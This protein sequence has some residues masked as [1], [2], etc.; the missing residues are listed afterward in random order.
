MKFAH[1]ADSHL[2]F[3]QYGLYQREEDFFD[4]FRRNIDKIINKKVDFVIHSGDLF[5]MPKP[6][7]K[8]LL[9][10]Q[11][12]LLKLR[13]ADIDVFAIAGN[14]DT[15]MRKDALPPQILSKNLGLKLISPKNPYY[16]YENVFIGG[17][18]YQSKPYKSNLIDAFKL[19]SQEAEKYEKRILVS[20]QGIDK[21]IPFA[22]ELEM[23][24]IPQNFNYY[25]CGHVHGRIVDDFGN[26]KLVYPGSTEIC[27]KSEIKDYQKN[28]KGFYIV[29]ISKDIL[30]IEKIDVK[31]RRESII[32]NIAYP[33]LNQDI[34]NLKEKIGS[35]DEKPILHLRVEGGNFNRSDVFEK[36]NTELGD[37]TLSI[38][39]D[40]KI[41]PL[42]K[43][44]E[45]M[46]LSTL[47]PKKLLI[48]GLLEYDNEDINDLAINLLDN[49]SKDKIEDAER[50]V[51]RFYKEY[52]D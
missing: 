41:E 15:V 50:L 31:P 13:E 48:N 20:H 30:E 19:L 38:K 24:D 44:S 6:S 42:I 22:F 26:G 27:R 18:P 39:P 1:I 45:A 28:G 10:F 52:F 4:V 37:L 25:A 33:N 51:E 23:A 40:F 21:Y 3:R 2:G 35:L 16:S 9:V 14:H 47:S 46:D 12:E 43:T 5:H 29:D 17:F 49:L 34:S 36:I 32:K 8:S 7:P 11:E